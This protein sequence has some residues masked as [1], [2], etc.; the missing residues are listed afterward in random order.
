MLGQATKTLADPTV[1]DAGAAKKRADLLMAEARGSFGRLQCQCAG[2]PELV[3]GR[4]V[5]VKG[6]LPQADVTAYIQ[7]VSHSFTDQGFYTKFEA[8]VEGYNV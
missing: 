2:L 5:E 7:K 6:F 8:K 3:P 4:N 1:K